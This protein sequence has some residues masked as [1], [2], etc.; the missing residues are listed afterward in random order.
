MF[1]SFRG[2]KN[3]LLITLSCVIVFSSCSLQKRLYNKGFY[4]SNS[5][6]NKKPAIHDT[7]KPISLLSTIK[8]IKKDNST[9]LLLAQVVNPIKTK[10]I[11]YNAVIPI[12][13][14]KLVKDP[15]D[16]IVMKSGARL[17][18]N[19]TEITSEKIFFKNCDSLSYSSS[20][21]YREDVQYI[22]YATLQKKKSVEKE[23]KSGF[24]S[25][26]I[27]IFILLILCVTIGFL[28][29]TIGFFIF[30]SI[31]ALILLLALFILFF[32]SVTK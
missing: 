21:I 9:P 16:T 23:K 30:M 32:I 31:A 22:H 10:G 19:V 12:T 7:A 18:G 17:L 26:R 15:C 11:N 25:A 14:Q 3:L 1:G 27:I 4:V 20:L 28:G 6:T 8:Q 5:Q 24:Y 29:G 13:K 2:M